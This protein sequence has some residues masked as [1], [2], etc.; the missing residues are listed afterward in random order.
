M[1][2]KSVNEMDERVR[3]V[4]MAT[5]PGAKVAELCRSFGISRQLGHKLLSRYE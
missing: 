4:V 2:F 1:P 3:F 5:E